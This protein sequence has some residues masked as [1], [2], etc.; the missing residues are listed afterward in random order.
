MVRAIYEYY[1]DYYA[2]NP[3]L[4][5]LDRPK[6]LTLLSPPG[7]WDRYGNDLFIHEVQGVVATLLSLKCRPQIRYQVGSD[8]ALKIAEEIKHQIE[9]EDNRGTLFKY[10]ANPQPVLLIFDRREDP[11]T[12]LLLQW[13]YQAMIHE[14]LTINNNEVNMSK[15]PGIKPELKTIVLTT[16][17][18]NFYHD[19]LYDNFGDIAVAVKDLTENYAKENKKNSNINSIEDMQR[20]VEEYGE[21]KKLSTSVS[22]H[23]S[24]LSEMN[25]IVD[26]RIL[27]KVSELQQEI[28]CGNDFT[29]HTKQLNELLGDETLNKDDALRLVII[30]FLRYESK[31][32]NSINTYKNK[33]RELDCDDFD[34]SLFDNVLEYIFIFILFYFFFFLLLLCYLFN[35]FAGEKNRNG[36]LFAKGVFGNV[37]SGLKKE[38]G[39]VRNVYTQ[40]RPLIM[41]YLNQLKSNKLKDSVFP[42]AYGSG[43]KN[44]PQNVIIYIVGGVTYEE[45]YYI[46]EFNE[47]NSDMNVVIGGTRMLNSTIFMGEVNSYCKL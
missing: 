27:F 34:L 39:G 16:E 14:L 8:G 20:F 47:E 9:V 45:A 28:V 15:V 7:K 32:K 37:V 30:Y 6:C 25:R 17:H 36:E 38:L 19:H 10:T 23:I 24:L 12:P 41:N 44:V 18:D 13:T 31:A 22:K 11:I 33:L 5:T 21:F 2:I 40:H 3:C 29:T 35:R 42:Y 4:F 1:A 26:N 46:H 43:G